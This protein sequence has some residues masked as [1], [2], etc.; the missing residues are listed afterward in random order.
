MNTNP[1][2]FEAATANIALMQ[3]WLSV[4][5]YPILQILA[6][7][8]SRGFYRLAGALPLCAMLPIFAVTIKAYCDHSNLWPLFLILASPAACVWTLIILAIA[9]KNVKQADK[10]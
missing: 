9:R 8:K 5:A 4:L 7:A 6:L 2:L 1:S 3:M 10:V